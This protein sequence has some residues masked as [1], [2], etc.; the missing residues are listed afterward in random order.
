MGDLEGGGGYK[1]CSHIKYY[2]TVMNYLVILSLIKPDRRII[3]FSY[4]YLLSLIS[5]IWSIH[6]YFIIPLSI[7]DR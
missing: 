2:W 3:D 7:I 6:C 4:L 1:F 5:S